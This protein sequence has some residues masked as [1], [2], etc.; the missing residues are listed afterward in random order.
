MSSGFLC[1]GSGNV[2][3]ELAPPPPARRSTTPVLTRVVL[4]ALARCLVSIHLYCGG[5]RRRG[6]SSFICFCAFGFRPRDA[7]EAAPGRR[8]THCLFGMRENVALKP[9]LDSSGDILLSTEWSCVS[10]YVAVQIE[11]IVHWRHCHDSPDVLM[12]SQI[13]HSCPRVGDVLVARGSAL[14]DRWC[15]SKQEMTTNCV[16]FVPW[17]FG[18]VS[19]CSSSIKS[20]LY[21]PVWPSWTPSSVS[22]D[23]GS[24]DLVLIEDNEIVRWEHDLH[25]GQR[26][27]GP[28]YN[29]RRA[30][31][32]LP[33]FGTSPLLKDKV[34]CHAEPPVHRR[35][36][37]K[38]R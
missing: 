20:M 21:F 16:L 4:Q 27:R 22:E 23:S 12:W 34:L 8:M 28:T 37:G 11:I 36:K 3:S 18:E 29:K 7:E 32:F 10:L 15:W 14:A 13:R 38:P 24:L 2:S 26:D 5:D 9:R 6:R 1:I 25:S 35:L 17:R 31:E 30:A 33:L 19:L